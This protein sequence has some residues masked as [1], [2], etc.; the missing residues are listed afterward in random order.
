MFRQPVSMFF[1]QESVMNRLTFTLL[2]ASFT[3]LHSAKAQD[4][5]ATADIKATAEINKLI[6]DLENGKFL[7]RKKA[8]DRLIKIGAPAVPAVAKGAESKVVEVRGRSMEILKELFNGKDATAKKAATAA[9]QKI[10]AGK[11]ELNAIRAKQILRPVGAANVPR[12]NQVGIRVAVGRMKVLTREINGVKHIDAEEKGTKYKIVHDPKKSITVEITKKDANG[13]PATKKYEA[14]DLADLKN[15]HPEAYKAFDRYSKPINMGRIN[16]G[17][18]AVRPAV[19]R[20]RA[21]PIGVKAADLDKVN[22]Q[23]E[24]LIKRL[25]DAAAKGKIDD[26]KKITE[27]LKQVQESVK[28]IRADA[29]KGIEGRMRKSLEARGLKIP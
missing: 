19:V 4:S 5:P 2:I 14:K 22:K 10:A 23:L 1:N 17:F 12:N 20:Q 16:I 11:N 28:K 29:D 15:K 27:E 3:C 26:V 13:K 7:D 9:L 25:G 8:T 24:D 6:D 18:G 21:L